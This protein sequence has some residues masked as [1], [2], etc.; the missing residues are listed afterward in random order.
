[1]ARRRSLKAHRPVGNS[2]CRYEHLSYNEDTNH[3]ENVSSGSL[4]GSMTST[5]TSWPTFPNDVT[6]ICTV[7]GNSELN[8]L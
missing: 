4:T 8:A 2:V 5:L 1:M 3:W 7:A 6:Q